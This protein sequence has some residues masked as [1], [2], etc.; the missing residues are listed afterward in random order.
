MLAVPLAGVHKALLL[1]DPAHLGLAQPAQGEQGVGQ[2]LLG[3][4]IQHIAL[5]PA[6]VRR[7]FQQEPAALLLD[8]GVVAGGDVVAAHLSNRSNF[9]RRLQLMQGLEVSPRR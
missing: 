7:L 5:V 2:L 1:R 3:Q 8:A 4:H 9:S 6:A